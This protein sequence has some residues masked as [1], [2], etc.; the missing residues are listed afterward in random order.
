MN[1]NEKYIKNVLVRLLHLWLMKRWFA[2]KLKSSFLNTAFPNLFKWF[3]SVEVK[4]T[5]ITNVLE[6]FNVKHLHSF[7]FCSLF[8]P[9]PFSLCK[10]NMLSI[11]RLIQKIYMWPGKIA[12]TILPQTWPGLLFRH[13]THMS[14]CYQ[15]CITGCMSGSR[16]SRDCFVIVW[17]KVKKWP[18]R[19]R[20]LSEVMLLTWLKQA[21]HSHIFPK[22]FF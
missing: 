17:T 16:S 20:A 1:E 15:I 2:Q 4:M 22:S 19:E 9:Q 3:L 13:H 5:E 7:F 18:K 12:V 14:N 8:L 11:L 6:F 21:Y 10:S